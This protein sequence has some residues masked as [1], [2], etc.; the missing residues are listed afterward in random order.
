MASES[1]YRRLCWWLPLSEADFLD[2]VLILSTGQP[3]RN[4]KDTLFVN[5]LRICQIMKFL[6]PV[7]IMVRWID[8]IE[9]PKKAKGPDESHRGH[10]AGREPPTHLGIDCKRFRLTQ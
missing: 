10:D 4:Q 3:E 9:A 7:L 2:Y 1:M 5:A 6:D 8:M